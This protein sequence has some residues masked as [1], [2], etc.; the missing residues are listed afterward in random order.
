MGK[1]SGCRRHGRGSTTDSPVVPGSDTPAM[2]QCQT[3]R[4]NRRMAYELKEAYSGA[5]AS[6]TLFL[7][8]EHVMGALDTWLAAPL[9]RESMM[10]VAHGTAL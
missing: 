9:L 4:P 5:Q 1:R 8:T 7:F 3:R 2:E 6:H 10:N